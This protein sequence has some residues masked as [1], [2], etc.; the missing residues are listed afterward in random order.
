ME[1]AC[2][3]GRS[4]R[5][6][7]EA[8]TTT[9]TSHWDAFWRSRDKAAIRDHAGLR[10]LAPAEFWQQFFTRELSAGRRARLID[11]GSGNGAVTAI[12]VAAAA[13]NG[14]Q[15]D[16]CC[17]DCSSAALAELRMRFP[18]VTCVAC[19]ARGLPYPDRSFD[20]VVSQFGIEYGG[21]P[22]FTEAARLVAEGGVLAA[23][24][25]SVASALHHECAENLAA[26]RA[27]SQSQLVASARDAFSAGFDLL[28]RRISASEFQRFDTR[29]AVAVEATKR[30]LH[31]MRPGALS[32]FLANLL[33]DL[34]YMYDRIRNYAPDKV[35]AWLDVMAGELVAYEGR[36]ASMT[37]CALDD[38]AIARVADKLSAAGFA[39]DPPRTLSLK[40]SGKPGGWILSAR[41][42]DH[43]S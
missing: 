8:E 15:L 35:F 27:V 43:P 3:F 32:G 13:A 25:H 18:Q 19:D 39:V 31:D 36:M 9:S 11:I 24:V 12:A 1:G 7:S 20:V 40:Q 41:R 30:I 21:E 26:A 37:E 4:R 6:L 42:A 10:D 16:A 34:G 5:R 14:A 22:A 17:I 28:A 23:I 33:R 29:L 38:E 2:G